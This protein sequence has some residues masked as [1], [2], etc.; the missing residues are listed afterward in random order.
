MMEKK[1]RKKGEK[2]YQSRQQTM[3]EMMLTSRFS[4]RNSPMLYGILYKSMTLA[5]CFALKTFDTFSNTR[6][7][8]APSYSRLVAS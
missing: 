8:Q 3:H 5:F 6:L 7:K 4:G 2:R 1:Q